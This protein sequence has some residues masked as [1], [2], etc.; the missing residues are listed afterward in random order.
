[1]KLAGRVSISA[2]AQTVWDALNA[3]E[4]LAKCIPGCEKLDRLAEDEYAVTQSVGIAAIKGRYTG[5]IAI[6]DKQAPARCTLHMEGKGPGGFMRGTSTV[7]LTEKGDA[8]ELAY[9]S[10][11]QVG[12][13]LASLGSRLIEPVARKLVQQFFEALEK[14]LG[15]SRSS[16]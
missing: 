16:G 15:R 9:D 4:V 14:H 10:L 8:T 6:R 3:P 2:P 7:A 1:M 12:G 5:K 11:V 13:M